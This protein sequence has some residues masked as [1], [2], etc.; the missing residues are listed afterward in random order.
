[1]PFGTDYKSA[2]QPDPRH[3]TSLLCSELLSERK[4]YPYLFFI[5]PQTRY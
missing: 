2:Y 5:C 3:R 4:I 1:M